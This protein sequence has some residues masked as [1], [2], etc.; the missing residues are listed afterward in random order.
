MGQLKQ[1]QMGPK[2][3][4]N[5]NQACPNVI[6]IQADLPR[7]LQ[8]VLRLRR[9]PSALAFSHSQ[10]DFGVNSQYSGIRT[11]GVSVVPYMAHDPNRKEHRY[12]AGEFLG[13]FDHGGSIPSL[14]PKTEI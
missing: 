1:W 3:P 13:C 4:S 14:I 8:Q 6:R 2:M 12:G 9:H 10:E 11:L 5:R 7:G